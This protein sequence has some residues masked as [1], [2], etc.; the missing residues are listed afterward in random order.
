M[1]MDDWGFRPPDD[2]GQPPVPPLRP[3]SSETAD[4]SDQAPPPP[5]LYS[6]FDWLTEVLIPAAVFGLL[7]SFLYYLID[8]RGAVGDPG[9]SSLRWVCFWFL[10]GTILTTRMRTRYGAHILALP[11][12]IGLGLA[13][14]LFVFHVT[15]YS[16]SFV[17]SS[18][19]VGQAFALIFNYALVGFIWWIAN[20]V[21][22]ACTAEENFET[23]LEQGLLTSMRRRARAKT[24]H[25]T[26]Q[27]R[28]PGW[29]LMWMSVAALITFA[30]GQHVVGAADSAH[31]RHAFLC[32]VSYSFFALLLL[33]LTSLSSLRMSAR[34]R[35]IRVESAITPVWAIASALIITAIL[36]LAALLPRVHAVERMR[37]RVAQIHGWRE[38]PE[39]PLNNAPPWGSRRPRGDP[40]GDRAADEDEGSAQGAKGEEAGQYERP[41]EGQA[42]TPTGGLG[43]REAGQATGGG[44]GKKGAESAS[45]AGTANSG[46]E[47]GPTTS[48]QSGKAHAQDQSQSAGRSQEKETTSQHSETAE[49]GQDQE[50]TAHSDR[51]RE[52]QFAGAIDLLKTLL[53]WLLILLGLL[54]LLLLLAYLI[55]KAYKHRKELPSFRGW[56][57]SLGELVVQAL[58]DTLK[59]I[60]AALVAAGAFLM[61]LLRWRPRHPPLTEEGLPVDPFTDI[62]ANRELADSLTPAQIVRHVYAAFQAFSELIGYPRSDSETPYEFCRSLPS[63][64]GGMPRSDADDLTALYVKAAYTPSDVGSDE[65]EQVRR[66]WERMQAPIDEALAN[67]KPART[68][69]T[70]KPAPTPA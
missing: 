19:T 60:L 63:Y 5:P 1:S 57:R 64:I 33:A 17:G 3:V 27:P 16:G 50:K 38:P 30:L 52:S 12:M 2:S 8:M 43:G 66:I 51:S 11:Y 10:L 59:R 15:M 31:R 69:K 20:L 32:M 56:L 26:D 46:G 65:V 7:G 39:T 68:P 45:E 47:G 54:L 42:A 44:G 14:V 6:P 21:T 62:F 55:Y 53:L 22:R 34:Q 70:P 9:I 36:L 25:Q 67:K 4:Q 40:G 28:H 23:M 35:Y 24:S 48:G 58:R 37:E 41:G 29:V 49:R 13:M 61:G 18:D